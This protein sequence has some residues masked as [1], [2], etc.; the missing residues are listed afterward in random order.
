MEITCS[1]Q[2][3]EIVDEESREALARA[4]IDNHNTIT[5]DEINRYC[6]E[7]TSR[8]QTLLATM[9]DEMIRDGQQLVFLSGE[10]DGYFTGSVLTHLMQSLRAQPGIMSYIQLFHTEL[11][12]VLGSRKVRMGL[13]LLASDGKRLWLEVETKE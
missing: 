3:F 2:R 7:F 4:Y 10:Q 8:L 1:H 5:P 13:G 9:V 12:T 11:L 6:G